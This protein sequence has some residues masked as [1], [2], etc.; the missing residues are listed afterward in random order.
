MTKILEP[1]SLSKPKVLPEAYFFCPTVRLLKLTSLLCPNVRFLPEL[2]SLSWPMSDS[3]LKPISL[4]LA[5]V[6]LLPSGTPKGS[7][8]LWGSYGSR[9]LRQLVPSH[10]IKSS[11]KCI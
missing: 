4:S 8:L 6:K 5:N 10:P 9:N 3:C 1:T 2:M 7:A 11:E